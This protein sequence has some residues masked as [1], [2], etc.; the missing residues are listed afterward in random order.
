MLRLKDQYLQ[1]WSTTVSDSSKLCYYFGYKLAFEHETYFH[2]LQVR[3][4][5]N[6]LA[7]FRVCAHDLDIEKGRHTGI[8]RNEHMYKLCGYGIEDEKKILFCP[9]YTTLRV[10]Y[11]PTKFYQHP[12]VHEFNMIMSTKS[13]VVLQGVATFLYHALILRKELQLFDLCRRTHLF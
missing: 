6:A 8:A 7:K 5:R 10:K 12:N 9:A 3:K 1:K 2:C 13:E 4:F 11:I